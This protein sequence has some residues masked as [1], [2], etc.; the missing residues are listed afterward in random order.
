[1][2]LAA[3]IYQVLDLTMVPCVLLNTLSV[4]NIAGNGVSMEHWHKYTERENRSARR[5]TRFSATFSTANIIGNGFEF[6]LG[7]TDEGLANN[8][9]DHR[10]FLKK[11]EF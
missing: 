7:F 8:R 1:M 6:N 4:A 5:K 3:I 10:K 11:I 9:L 2:K